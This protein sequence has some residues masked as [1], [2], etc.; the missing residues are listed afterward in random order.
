MPKLVA[1]MDGVS[2]DEERY[3]CLKIGHS[4]TEYE[5]TAAVMNDNSDAHNAFWTHRTFNGGIAAAK[6]P[7]REYFDCQDSGRFAKLSGILFH[8]IRI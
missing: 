8:L 5:V 1:A 2:I 7:K 6:D 3:S 4:V